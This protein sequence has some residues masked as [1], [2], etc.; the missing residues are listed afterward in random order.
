MRCPSGPLS[1]GRSF[2]RTYPTIVRHVLPSYGVSYQNIYIYIYIYTCET[3]SDHAI[4]YDHETCLWHMCCDY[5]SKERMDARC[6]LLWSPVT[7][8]DHRTYFLIVVMCV[9]STAQL[10]IHSSHFI[11]YGSQM[12][13]H[14]S[15]FTVSCSH[16]KIHICL[17]K[18]IAPCP[19]APSPS[20]P[21]A[22]LDSFLAMGHVR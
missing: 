1:V 12:T 8:F 7:S 15:Y 5:D 13:F 4:F 9:A 17:I 21:P 2:L 16:H 10:L 14:N 18:V 6:V 19:S 20:P 22:F 3:L 11:V